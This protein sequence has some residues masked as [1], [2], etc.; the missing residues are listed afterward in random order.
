MSWTLGSGQPQ[1]ELGD[2]LR[3]VAEFYHQ[4]ARRRLEWLRIVLPIGFTLLLGGTA[5][6]VYALV[7]FIPWI[8]ILKQF[9][10]P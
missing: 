2:A 5:V 9:A 1:A 10:A 3:Y 7:T 4:R 8:T 6:L